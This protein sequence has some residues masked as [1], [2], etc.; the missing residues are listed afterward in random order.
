MGQEQTF[1]EQKCN[2][3][4][5]MKIRILLRSVGNAKHL[6]HLKNHMD[7]AQHFFFTSSKVFLRNACFKLQFTDSRL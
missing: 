5:W 4:Y 1:V 7:N 3:L 6:N 2:V